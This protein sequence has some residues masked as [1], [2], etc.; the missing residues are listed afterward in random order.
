MFCHSSV[1]FRYV[2]EDKGEVFWDRSCSGTANTE[3]APG[4]GN[5]S[6]VRSAQLLAFVASKVV[7]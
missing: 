6:K 7:L 3:D 2:E 1:F 5:G 4:K